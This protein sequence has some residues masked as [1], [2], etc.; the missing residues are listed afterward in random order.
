LEQHPLPETQIDAAAHFFMPE[1]QL[2]SHAVPLH[3]AV[4]PA[5][6]LQGSQEAPQASVELFSTQAPE[7]MC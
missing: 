7:H 6:D 3:V 5:G 1:A 4:A 2:K